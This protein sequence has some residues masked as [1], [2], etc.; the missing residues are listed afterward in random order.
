M[1]C[2]T[3]IASI[4]N[5]VDAHHVSPASVKALL[6]NLIFVSALLFAFCMPLLTTFGHDDLAAADQRQFA[7]AVTGRSWVAGENHNQPDRD[8]RVAHIAECAVDVN[9]TG[10]QSVW[11]YFIISTYFMRTAYVCLTT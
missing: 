6:D 4:F 9:S 11:D 2:S 10:C 7:L 8:S 3:A 5:P 1:G